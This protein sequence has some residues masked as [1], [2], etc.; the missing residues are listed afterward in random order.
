LASERDA[1]TAQEVRARYLALRG[2]DEAVLQ[3]DL[4]FFEAA[5]CIK[6]LASVMISLGAGA[7]AVGMRPGAEAIM[8]SRMPRFAV[9]YKRWLALTGIRLPDVE[10]MLVGH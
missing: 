6:R 3:L 8:S 2:W 5:A 1:E 4:D 9:V 7:D 10:T